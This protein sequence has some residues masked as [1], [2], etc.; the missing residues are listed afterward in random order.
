M[1]MSLVDDKKAARLT[2]HQTREK[3][4]SNIL[5]DTPVGLAKQ[6]SKL[7]SGF[8]RGSLISGFLSIGDEISTHPTLLK[9]LS[10]G[11]DLC[12][13]VVVQANAPLVFRAWKEG[14]ELEKGPLGTR[15]PIGSMETVVP[16]VMLVPLLS[17]DLSGNRIGWGGG[18]YDRTLA[19][20]KKQRRRVTALGVGYDDQEVARVPVDE[21]DVK[22]DWIVTEKRAIEIMKEG[23]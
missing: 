2:A 18:F 8:K 11:F 14:D 15:H 6:V 5:D 23:L 22:M 4:N 20:Y 10:D 21:F 7:L 16:D 19:D 17:Y 3:I 9:L 1:P 13:P 12:L